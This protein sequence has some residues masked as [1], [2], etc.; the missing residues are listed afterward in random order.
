MRYPIFSPFPEEASWMN[1]GTTLMLPTIMALYVAS[2][3]NVRRMSESITDATAGM[4]ED[5]VRD[6]KMT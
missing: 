5:M 6:V 2:L 4:K 3:E 1:S